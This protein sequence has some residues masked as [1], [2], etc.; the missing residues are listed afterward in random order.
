[1]IRLTVGERAAIRTA[2]PRLVI[3]VEADFPDEQLLLTPAPHPIKWNGKTYLGGLA[4]DVKVP[5]AEL[6]GE[7]QAGELLLDGLT[8]AAISLAL[9]ED[10][11]GTPARVIVGARDADTGL[12]IGPGWRRFEGTLAEVRIGPPGST[13]ASAGT[14]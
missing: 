3:L 9:N 13:T 14:T 12:P 4:L 2:N 10:I 5:V 6:N 1:M 11:D 7:I 8:P